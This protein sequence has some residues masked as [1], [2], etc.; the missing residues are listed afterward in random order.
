MFFVTATGLLPQDT[1]TAFDIHDARTC[2]RASPCQIAPGAA[3]IEV[4]LRRNLSPR[5]RRARPP[6]AAPRAPRPSKRPGN[7][8]PHSPAKA[9]AGTATGEPAAKPLTR[10]QKLAKAIRNVSG[11]SAGGLKRKAGLR[12]RVRRRYRP[13]KWPTPTRPVRKHRRWPR[14][15][16]GRTLND[17]LS[18]D[19][20]LS[21]RVKRTVVSVLPRDA[22]MIA[23]RRGTTIRIRGLV[24]H[25]ALET[26]PGPC[27]RAEG[28][29]SV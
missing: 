7:P 21:S 16:R 10:K 5:H 27:S 15:Q 25:L 6:R 18:R 9:G 8:P 22:A 23:L 11:G 13:Q 4:R 19:P 17:Q 24:V 2:G 29:I 12:T 3:S 26:A 28:V 1:D 20:P 14:H